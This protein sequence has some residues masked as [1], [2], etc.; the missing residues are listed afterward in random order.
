MKW[1]GLLA[2][3][4]LGA[5]CGDDSCA[6]VCKVPSTGPCAGQDEAACRSRCT[7][8]TSG[9]KTECVKCMIK[10]S[11]WRGLTCRCNT[12]ST[13]S[14]CSFGPEGEGCYLAGTCTAADERCTGLEL[15]EASG[16]LCI[17]ACGS[18]DGG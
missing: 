8:R 14:P 12:N 4:L 2:L 17:G 1:A 7:T 6:R 3:G 18:A 13:C 10:Y 9:L 5:S 16:S 15:Y 11:G